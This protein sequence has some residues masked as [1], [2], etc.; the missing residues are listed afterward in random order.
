[1]SGDT[2][3][4]LCEGLPVENSCRVPTSKFPGFVR[5][6]YTA[7]VTLPSAQP[8][9]QF[10]WSAGERNNGI[11]NIAN[12]GGFNI[13]IECGLNNVFKYDNSSPR[14]TVAPFPYI[15]VNQ[16]NIFL[17]SPVDPDG[18]S[19][20]SFSHLPKSGG[21]GTTYGLGPWNDINYDNTGTPAYTLVNPINS[22]AANPY[23]IDPF[24][25]AASFT[26]QTLGKFVLAFRCNEYD[27]ASG[28]MTGY[29]FRD[30]QVSVLDC[31]ST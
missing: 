26:P 31:N 24:S 7:T 4:Q 16:P 17:N 9:W 28:I 14:F 11:A 25:G 13:F 8:D 21:P 10:W 5:K 23:T 19:L 6:R 27:R 20:Y 22:T 15:C 1:G 29:I 3:D 30:V 12:S 2:L 18:D